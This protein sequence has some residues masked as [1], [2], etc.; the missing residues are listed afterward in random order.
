M[1]TPPAR[2]LRPEESEEAAAV[3]LEA[4][5]AEPTL[6]WVW[7]DDGRWRTVG[8]AFIDRLIEVRV[9]GGEPWVTED[10]TAVALW[11][12]PGGIYSSRPGLWD[13]FTGLTTPAEAARLDAYDRLADQAQPPQPRWYLGVLAVRPDQRGRGRSR[14][15]LTP[16]LD[17]A[18]RAGIPA[19]LETAT[20][21]NL[22]IY[23]RFG[24]E[25]H[26]EID[27]PD[28]GPHLWVLRRSPERSG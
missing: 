18:D 7:P 19:T 6:R 28:G 25:V 10:V 5:D 2:R 4:F 26:A 11:D 15:V 23:A 21:V 9:S 13:E 12:P 22:A 17:A 20:P 8:R 1:P 24:F 14:E 3:I 16:V 27:L